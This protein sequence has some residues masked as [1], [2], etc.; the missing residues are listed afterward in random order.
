MISKPRNF[1]FIQNWYSWP[2]AVLILLLATLFFVSCEPATNYR[3]TIEKLTQMVEWELRDKELHGISFVLVDDQRIIWSTGFGYAD[4]EKKIAAKGNTIYRVASVSKLFTDIGIMQL[5]ERGEV[6]IDK[7]VSDYLPEF[8]PQNPFD[9]QIT[10][11]QLM[12]HRS[13]IVREPPVGNYF[14]SS[15]P[16]L[17]ETVESLN[18]TRVVYEPEKRTKYS[19]A[20]IAVAG[21]VIERLTPLTGL[22]GTFFADHMK[23]AIL[24]PSGMNNSSFTLTEKVQ[25]KLA[26][27]VMWR[28]DG[29]IFDAPVFEFGMSPAA[30]LY[31]NM[32]DIGSFLMALFR[33][34]GEDAPLLQSK[35]LQ[36]MYEIQFVKEGEKR[37][38]GLGFSISEL[39]GKRRIGHS[40]AVY[41]FATEFAAL[42]DQKLGVCVVTNTDVANAVTRKIANYALRLM[43]AAK[44]KS[45]LPEITHPQPIDPEMAK[46][47]SG[48]Y[49]GG[50]RTL[51]LLERRGKLFADFG[52]G[53]RELRML[54]DTLF[55]EDKLEIGQKIQ[56]HGYKLIIGQDT[57]SRRIREK[58]QPVP[59]RWKGLIGEYGWDHN[60]LYI[61]EN[62][63]KLYALIEWIEYDP[64]EEISENVFAFPDYG[65]YH[66]E[67]L[68]FTRDALDQAT[69]VE[70][71]SIVF[72]RRPTGLTDNESFRITPVRPVEEIRAIA[73]GTKPPKETDILRNPDLIDIS[74][75]TPHIRFDI[76]YATEN[77]VF[78]SVFYP[79]AKAFLQHPAAQAL[80]RA[81]Q[82]LEELGLGI[83]VFDAYRPWYV[84]KM[85]WEA[86]PEDKRIFVADPS[87]GS[88][89]NRGC[90]VDITL[91]DLKTGIPVEMT[92][93]YDEFSDRSFAYYA[94]GT[95]LQRWYRNLLIDVM[96]N[97]GFD[98]YQ[99]EWWHFDYVDWKEYPILN[100]QFTEIISERK[101]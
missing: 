58:P 4:P 46:T 33:N 30:N 85:F 64:L 34:S 20:G 96:K 16:S 86:T 45:P 74:T 50:K 42:P 25:N 77:N 29:R 27:A 71:A 63:G 87:K 93:G 68:I 100:L 95:S 60:V 59:E 80:L 89:H 79:E 48:Y 43:S 17:M 35:T 101:N 83:L 76:R 57:L 72:K 91:Y 97:E 19:N 92:G 69:E 21:L 2:L 82:R 75:I 22:K 88:R 3:P 62:N 31:T 56:I 8:H 28:Y 61:L 78:G 5:A 15:E 53:P 7:P 9:K 54:G 26:K 37:G 65:M 67:K 66:G 81:H 14:D 23:E 40:G 1:A 24:E 52:F 10:L 38:F 84:T 99:W 41:G 90:A 6:D 39:D 32:H 47:M 44:S 98:V 49:V 70:A 94:G 55:V 13:G 51:E 73:L 36:Q 12:S 18:K 11:R